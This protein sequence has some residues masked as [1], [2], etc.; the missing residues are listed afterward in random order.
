M[1]WSC[2]SS[3]PDPAHRKSAPAVGLGFAQNDTLK[4]LTWYSWNMFETWH[5]SWNLLSLGQDLVG[6]RGSYMS[7][8]Y[9]Q[10]DEPND[11][12]CR[13]YPM[14]PLREILKPTPNRRFVNWVDHTIASSSWTGLLT[15]AQMHGAKWV[16][17]T[18]KTTIVSTPCTL[19]SL[20]EGPA[21]LHRLCENRV[22]QGMTKAKSCWLIIFRLIMTIFNH[23]TGILHVFSDTPNYH[24]DGYPLEIF[25][26]AIENG[27]LSLIFP[28]KMVIFQFVMYTFTRPGNPAA[29]SSVTNI[30]SGC[31]IPVTSGHKVMINS[32]QRQTHNN[33]YIYIWLVVSTP[34]KNITVVR[35]D[36]HPNYWGK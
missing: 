25:H 13:M 34:L 12:P 29:W 7:C 30:P 26:I 21:F 32:I 16:K 5:G 9:T 14:S 4:L 11:S 27:H 8:L 15:T 17:G 3:E 33:T 19:A 10:C 1:A 18:C 36:H 24:L 20:S 2:F 6:P 31:I 28:L 22:C 23:L 35:L